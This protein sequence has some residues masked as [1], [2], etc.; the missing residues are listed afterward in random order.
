MD[1]VLGDS[2]VVDEQPIDIHQYSR[3]IRAALPR[4]AAFAVVAA[5]IAVVV[6]VSH[7]SKPSYAAS[8]TILA[9][10]ALDST[11]AT[12]LDEYQPAPRNGQSADDHDEGAVSRRRRVA[13][14]S[15]DELRSVV[16]SS[17]DPNGGRDH[18]HR[19]WLD[20]SAAAAARA[21]AV[22]NALVTSEQRIEEQSSTDA[23]RNALAELAQ[24]K[25]SGADKFAIQAVESQIALVAAGSLGAATGFQLLQPPEP[26]ADR[27]RRHRG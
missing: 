10:D 1:W 3:A 25:A 22:A 4:I 21:N 2:A 13:G 7:P 14:H 15:V 9:R 11:Q 12:G 18:D 8:T 16:R 23:R 26:Q 27:H 17:V 24:L 20:A 5:A 6:L 19:R